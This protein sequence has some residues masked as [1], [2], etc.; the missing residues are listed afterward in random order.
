M[1]AQLGHAT[2]VDDADLPVGAGCE[3]HVVGD[4]DDGAAGL[5]NE[6]AEDGEHLLTRMRVEIAGRLVGQD[7]QRLVGKG[8]SD[9]DALALTA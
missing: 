3:V 9:G 6:A 1:S 7:D 4:H 2:A 5:V 8:A